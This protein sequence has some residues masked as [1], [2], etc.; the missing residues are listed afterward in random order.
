MDA[1]K[2]EREYNEFKFFLKKKLDISKFAAY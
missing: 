1:T 2:K